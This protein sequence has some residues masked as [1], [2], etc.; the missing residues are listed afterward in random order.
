ME[1]LYGVWFNR[2]SYGSVFVVGPFRAQEL[3]GCFVFG[4]IC[5]RMLLRI[6]SSAEDAK[7]LFPH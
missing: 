4:F 6:G 1:E 3:K 7:A 5:F 2:L